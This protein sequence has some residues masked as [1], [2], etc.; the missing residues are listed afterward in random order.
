MKDR[1]HPTFTRFA[2]A[3]FAER[4]DLRVLRELCNLYLV[5][6]HDEFLLYSPFTLVEIV[7]GPRKLFNL[8]RGIG[9]VLNEAHLEVSFSRLWLSF[10]GLEI[11]VSEAFIPRVAIHYTLAAAG[12]DVSN[13][14]V[15]TVI[16]RNHQIEV[17]VPCSSDVWQRVKQRG[18]V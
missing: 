6:V 16:N 7:E 8:Y 4:F 11:D 1:S 18:H 10:N 12:P 13:V 15:I 14:S 2:A 9:I 17:N 3:V 5:K